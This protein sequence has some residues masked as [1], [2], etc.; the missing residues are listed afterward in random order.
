MADPLE[1]LLRRA[2]LNDRQRAGLW[3]LYE[4]SKNP[5]DLAARLKSMDIP[6]DVKAQLWDLK[7]QDGPPEPTWSDKLGLNAPVPSMPSLGRAEPLAAASAGFMRGVGSGA[8]D[9]AQGVASALMGTANSIASVEDQGAASA[10]SAAKKP[11]QPAP[12]REMPVPANLSGKVGTMLPDIAMS[13]MPV[14]E[15]AAAV[16]G[17]LP[18]ATRAGAN[19]EKV[20]GAAKNIPIDVKGVGDAALRINQLAER[21]GSMPMAVRKILNRMTD[22]GKAPMTYEEARDFATNIGRLSKDEMGRL[23]PVVKR[24]VAN[25]AAELNKANADAAKIAGK[26]AEYKSAMREYANAMRMR[27]AMDA[28]IRHSKKAALGAAGLGGAYYLFG[29]D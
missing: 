8:V 17:A 14:G 23:T 18:S 6:Q 2:S 5:D 11:Y 19:F 27:D 28:V 24:E 20:M 3:D 16:K 26:G 7:A 12:S 9:M 15:G 22:P 29:K 25:L 4:A 1:D 21:G 13:V 10:A